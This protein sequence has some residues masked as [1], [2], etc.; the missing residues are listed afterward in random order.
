MQRARLL[1]IA[2]FMA[3]LARYLNIELR[4]NRLGASPDTWIRPDA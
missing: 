4:A 1:Y 2:M 3:T